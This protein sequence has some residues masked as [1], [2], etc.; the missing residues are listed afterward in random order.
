MH[1]TVIAQNIIDEAE[2]HGKVKELFLEIGELAHVPPDELLATLGKMVDWKI[3]SEIILA[4]VKCECGFSGAPTILER[5]H[6]SI[7][8][9][10]PKCEGVP[11]II[12]GDKIVIKR[13]VVE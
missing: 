4:K 3:H 5:G 6:D 9:E 11:R 7:L 1:E 2:K 10:C 13:V 8:I 12:E